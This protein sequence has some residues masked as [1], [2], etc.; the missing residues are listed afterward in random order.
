MVI[1]YL[2]TSRFSCP[3]YPLDDD[4]DPKCSW[5]Q[6]P[7]QSDRG[8]ESCL[9]T[10]NICLLGSQ[11]Y[12]PNLAGTASEEPRFVCKRMAGGYSV[13]FLIPVAINYNRICNVVAVQVGALAIVFFSW[14]FPITSS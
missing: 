10:L 12:R 2:K 4:I 9:S 1:Q 7:I 6:R 5:C 11:C 8:F 3:T 14:H 13:V